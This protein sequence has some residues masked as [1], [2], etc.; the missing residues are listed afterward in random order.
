MLD[1]AKGRVCDWSVGDEPVG[2]CE[3][4]RAV[5]AACAILAIADG[6]IAPDDRR[7]LF[8]AICDY[9]RVIGFSD[10]ELLRELAVHE[11]NFAVDRAFGHAHAAAQ[12][13]P[14]ARQ[15]QAALRLL[16]A[17]RFLVI[18]D[19]IAHLRDFRAILTIKTLLGLERGHG[20]P[21]RPVA[22]DLARLPGGL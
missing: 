15:R 7:R 14:V 21:A 5:A 10:T 9:A 3:M 6:K 12:I 20:Q 2:T 1:T 4:M 16:D 11:R 17:C 8:R 13:R 19:G 18:A 22:I